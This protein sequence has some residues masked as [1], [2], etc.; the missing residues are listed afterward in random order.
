MSNQIDFQF[1]ID[2][3]V[4]GDPLAAEKYLETIVIKNLSRDERGQLAKLC[5]QNKLPFYGI[6][7]LKPIMRDRSL[8]T[9]PPTQ[10]ELSEYALLLARAG[11]TNESFFWLNQIRGEEYPILPF[12]RGMIHIMRWEYSNARIELEKYLDNR[13]FEKPSDETVTLINLAMCY[14]F[15]GEF[16]SAMEAIDQ[17]KATSP[18]SIDLRLQ[19]HHDYLHAQILTLNGN[20]AVAK[21]EWKRYRDKYPNNAQ[22]NLN[23]E[24]WELYLQHLEFGWTKSLANSFETLRERASKRGASELIRDLDKYL[25]LFG[26]DSSPLLRV[27]YGT[28]YDEYKQHIELLAPRIEFPQSQLIGDQSTRCDSILDPTEALFN[29]SPILKRGQLQHRALVSI[30]SDLYKPI[31]PGALFTTLFPGEYYDVDSCNMRVFK[32][33]SRLNAELREQSLP[34]NVGNN[35][36]GYFLNCESPIRILM[37]KGEKRLFE[38]FELRRLID[39]YGPNWFGAAEAAQSL[40]IPRSSANRI[41]LDLVDR[42]FLVVEGKGK[43]TRYRSSKFTG[44]KVA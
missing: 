6:R 19:R 22:N 24:K 5:R 27:Y 30:C 16:D 11:A 43:K 40:D 34:F 14:L 36:E 21:Q 4:A 18:W 1:L 39:A 32:Y 15:S 23:L 38:N 10:S 44:K 37:T 28:P 33:V 7:C 25:G 12:Y 29:N 41:L 13:N 20:W 8:Y 26:P 2:C 35:E 9:E 42:K 17:A 3:F 31:S